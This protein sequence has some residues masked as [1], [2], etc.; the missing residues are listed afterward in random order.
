MLAGVRNP[1]FNLMPAKKGKP[2]DASPEY[3]A[4]L[5]SL[6][7]DGHSHHYLYLDK[8]LSYD[9]KQTAMGSEIF[10]KKGLLEYIKTGVFLETYIAHYGSGKGI[11]QIALQG[12][13]LHELLKYCSE[14][15]ALPA[16]AKI[17]TEIPLPYSY[18]AGEF[19]SD[20]LPFMKTIDSDP[21]KVR[22]CYCF[23][24]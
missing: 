19:Y 3:K 5:R 2:K 6:G 4:M 8:L 1:N 12:A 9:F 24:N 23:D 17:E 18:F 15:E 22:L 14:I 21:A 11:H 20:Y 13:S 7:I 16:R 10:S